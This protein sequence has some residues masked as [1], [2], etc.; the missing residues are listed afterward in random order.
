MKGD[1]DSQFFDAQGMTR[2]GSRIAMVSMLATG[3]DYY[4]EAGQE[5]MV[6]AVQRAARKL[7]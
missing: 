3:Q 1:P 5:P 2:V 4:Y 7:T 6:A